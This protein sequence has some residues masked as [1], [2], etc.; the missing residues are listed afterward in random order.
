MGRNKFIKKF[1]SFLYDSN[2]NLGRKDSKT[3]HQFIMDCITLVEEFLETNEKTPTQQP[4][5]SRQKQVSSKDIMVIKP[6]I[7]NTK[8]AN[9]MTQSKSMKLDEKG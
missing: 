5:S 1:K 8:G 3:K 2:V 4:K 7:Q 6:K 9:I